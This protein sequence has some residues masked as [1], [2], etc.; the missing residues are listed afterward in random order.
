ADDFDAELTD[1]SSTVESSSVT[2]DSSETLAESSDE[3][4]EDLTLDDETILLDTDD[5]F[6]APLEEC[7]E[8]LTTALPALTAKI[9]DTNATGVINGGVRYA[10][11][12]YS[13]SRS[14]TK[15]CLTILSIFSFV[16]SQS[17]L[18]TT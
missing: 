1:V 9:I 3:L 18:T 4:T 13:S 10:I 2:S 11:R 7:V 12:Y 5:D 14:K 15:A 16:L 8:T 6:A 17:S